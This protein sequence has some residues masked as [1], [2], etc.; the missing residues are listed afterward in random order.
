MIRFQGLDE[1]AA[2]VLEGRGEQAIGALL[3]AAGLSSKLEGEDLTVFPGTAHDLSFDAHDDHRLA[4][5]S[6]VLARLHGVHLRLRGK[7]SV[8]KSFPHFWTEAAE[9][10]AQVEAWT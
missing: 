2:R 6:A 10:G 9:A 3:G 8:A 1:I 7:E 4:M 5:S